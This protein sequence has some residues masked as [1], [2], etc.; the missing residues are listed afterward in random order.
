MRLLAS[1]N[2]GTAWVPNWLAPPNDDNDQTWA[3]Q[4]GTWT[5]V[6]KAIGDTWD[7]IYALGMWFGCG[8]GP[9]TIEI[10]DIVLS[11]EGDAIDPSCWNGVTLSA[12]DT[13]E[14]CSVDLLDLANVAADWLLDVN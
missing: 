2:D 9:A 13:N 6:T 8:T 3:A 14:D 5:K 12:A 1:N 4:S 11:L 10:A 7:D